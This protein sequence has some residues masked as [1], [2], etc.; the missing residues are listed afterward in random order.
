[1]FAVLIPG[2]I[3]T[4]PQLRLALIYADTWNEINPDETAHVFQPVV[5][6]DD[7]EL[8]D[9]FTDADDSTYRQKISALKKQS[10]EPKR[11]R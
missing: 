9:I 1:M 2:M 5:Y 7:E 10:T 8:E 4:C 11:K 6:G 3:K